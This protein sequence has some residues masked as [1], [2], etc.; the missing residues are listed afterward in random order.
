MVLQVTAQELARVHRHRA[1]QKH[2]DIPQAPGFL[3][4]AEPVQKA[5]SATDRECGYDHR[6]AAGDGARHDFLQGSGRIDPLVQ[7][8]AVGDQSGSVPSCGAAE[9]YVLETDRSPRANAVRDL[10]AD[11][12]TR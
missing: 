1:I 11:T 7:S 12:W 2:R 3:Q 8:V 9:A 6:S 4:P 5:L 10:Q